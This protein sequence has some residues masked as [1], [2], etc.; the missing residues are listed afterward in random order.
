MAKLLTP[1][2]RR[3]V[4]LGG[5]ALLAMYTLPFFRGFLAPWLE[6]DILGINVLWILAVLALATVV[7]GIKSDL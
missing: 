7:L 2:R 1:L 3:Q 4:L 6:R 5:T